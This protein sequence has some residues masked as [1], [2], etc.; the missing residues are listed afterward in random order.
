MAASRPEVLVLDVNETLS[1]LTPSAADL[2]K[3]GIDQIRRGGQ[4]DLPDFRLASVFDDVVRAN[5]SSRAGLLLEVRIPV[6]GAKQRS[7]DSNWYNEPHAKPA[8]LLWAWRRISHRS[9][10]DRSAP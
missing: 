1:D 6:P 8:R 10:L 9:P 4:V 3:E 5:E 2:P 7:D